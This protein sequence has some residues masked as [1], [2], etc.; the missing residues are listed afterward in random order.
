MFKSLCIFC[1][2]L[3]SS[4]S[5]ADYSSHSSAQHLR[6]DM[7]A[8]GFDAV[9]INNILGSA[10][11]QEAILTAIARPAEKAKPWYDYRKIF[12]DEKRIANGVTF[13]NENAQALM[14]ASEKYGVPAEIIVAIIGVETRYGK[15]TGSYRVI[16]ALT[17]LGFDYPPRSD[18]FY[19]EL[20]HFLLLTKQ[21]G[22]DPLTLKG[23][24]AGAMGFGQFMP[25]SYLHYAIDFDGD[26]KVDIWNNPTDAIG[27]VAHYLYAHKW[28]QGQPIICSANVADKKAL[29]NTPDDVFNILIKPEKNVKSIAAIGL[30]CD[31]KLFIDSSVQLQPFR[32]EMSEQEFAYWL[33]FDNFYVITRYNHSHMYALAVYQLSQEIKL[34]REASN[35]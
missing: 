30:A 21:Q 35:P 16:D 29:R 22:V 24:Y 34:K 15:V 17:T 20:K 8:E 23:S 9:E 32:V 10:N 11:R 28:Q 7:K 13:W 31:T 14:T 25:S 33:G 5:L 12:L 4:M 3:F 2:V 19:S 6:D 26:N 27:S 1:V 18:F